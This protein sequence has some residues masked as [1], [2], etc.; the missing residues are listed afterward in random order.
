MAAEEEKDALHAPVRA[1]CDQHP[2][3]DGDR[4]HAHPRRHVSEAEGGGHARELGH[5]GAEVGD[6][7][8]EHGEGRDLQ[9]E[10]LA[11]ERRQALTGDHPHARAHLLGDGQDRR[12]EQ[13]HPEQLV[14][15]LAPTTDHVVMPPASLSELAVISPGPMTARNI[16]RRVRPIR[17]RARPAPCFVRRAVHSSPEDA[18]QSLLPGQGSTRSMASSTVTMPCSTPSAS[19]TGRASRL[20]LAIVWVTSSSRRRRGH[21]IGSAVMKSRTRRLPGTVSRSRSE[22]DAEQPLTLV[23]RRRCS[24]RSRP[25]APG[26]A[27]ARSPRPAVTSGGTDGEGGGHDAAGR[28]LGVGEQLADLGR[29]SRDP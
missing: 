28:V 27:A 14:A 21:G 26:R 4:R 8:G 23:G 24:R 29:A 2:D 19:T 6:Q 9:A 18:R 22:I 17:P 5:R 10:A 11:D 25:R 12:D 1:A 15:V 3:P 16:S 7:H 13:Q 20:Y